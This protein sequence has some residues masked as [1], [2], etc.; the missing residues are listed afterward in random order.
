[1]HRL[2]SPHPFRSENAPSFPLRAVIAAI[3]IWLLPSAA[4]ARQDEGEPRWGA[5]TELTLTD[6]SGNQELT[7]LTTAFT[8]R[9][10]RSEIFSMELNLQGRYGSSDGE[11]VAENY[12]GRLSLD[13]AP[14]RRWSPFLY[15]HAEHDPF[16]R[17]ALR[18]SSGAGAR[19]RLYREPNR[20]EASISLAMLH[21]YEAI[22]P[23]ESETVTNRARAN[24]GLNGS[25]RVREGV[26]FTHRTEFQPIVDQVEDYHLT[27]ESVLRIR[28]T[29]HVAL[30]ISHEYNRESMPATDI[31]PDDRLI[32]AGVQ[33]E[34]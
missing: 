10:L 28:V 29:N 14:M 5:S 24:F 13:L 34:L 33:V 12:K 21:S 27:L 3:T 15:S 8:L 19:Y 22:S 16:R 1:M 26:T 17:L 7:L 2:P 31:H 32:K 18:M 23:R 4:L 20:G 25:Y 9:H 6:A 30:T 11:Q